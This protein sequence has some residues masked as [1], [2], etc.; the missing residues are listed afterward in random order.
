MPVDN[1]RRARFRNLSLLLLALALALPA[2]TT[3]ASVRVHGTPGEGREPGFAFDLHYARE[4]IRLDYDD[5]GGGGPLRLTYL[6]VGFHEALATGV[7]GTVRIGGIEGTQNRRETTADLDPDGYYAEID[8]D[9]IWPGGGPVGLGLGARW[10]YTDI[11]D[12][13]LTLDWH[14][15][16]LRAAV[17]GAVGPRIS[18][19]LGVAVTEVDG[20]ERL[21]GETRS[22]SDFSIRGRESAFLQFDFRSGHRGAVRFRVRGGNPKEAFISFE[23]SY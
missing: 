2:K 4:D 13:D 5:G 18:A 9:G 8:A 6:G 20:R 1:R 23:H 14:T 11:D 16:E 12:S 19:R 17:V 7:R 21:R 3:F 22:S 15:W 10:R